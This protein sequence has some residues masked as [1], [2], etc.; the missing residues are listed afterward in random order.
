[1][2]DRPHHRLDDRGRDALRD[3]AAD[4]I[5]SF[6]GEHNRKQ[7]TKKEMRWG[8]HGS[9]SLVIAGQREGL[10]YDHES[11]RGGDVIEFIRLELHCSFGEAL[12][13]AAQYVSELRSSPSPSATPRSRP[14][15]Y[16]ADDH[17]EEQR[18]ARALAIWCDAEPLRGTLADQYL[19]SRCL[20]LPSSAS[21]AL[22]FHPCCPW[23]N[24]TVPALIG[25]ITDALT[26]EPTGI[27]R[28]GLTLDGRKIAPKALGVKA[29]GAVKLS[30]N[31]VDHLVIA[32]GIETALSATALGYGPAWSVIDAGGIAKFPV[33]PG[34][35]RLTI[36]V[37]HDASGRG[38]RATETCTRRWRWDGKYVCTIIA[39]K[40]GDDL[41]DV[42]QRL[43]REAGD[44]S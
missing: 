31:I 25:L 35:D 23:G 26:N 11:G 13:Y 30:R 2:S 24:G 6:R 7:S 22:R 32:E 19:Q 12:D 10:W 21:D 17:D 9:L 38:Q 3:A 5:T 37:D 40:L 18:I 42:L 4:I 43:A 8:N 39:D 33:L 1:M 28:I 27:Q 34:I 29:D 36:A 15:K 44:A 16:I 41:N 20:V 14:P